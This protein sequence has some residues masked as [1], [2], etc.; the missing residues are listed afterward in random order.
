MHTTTLRSVA[1]SVMMVLPQSLLDRLDLDAGGAVDLTIENGRLIVA[2]RPVPHPSL[3]DLLAEHTSLDR[4]PH[5]ERAWLD[6]GP[7]G[8]EF[9]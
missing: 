8:R 4:R 5:E 3:D 1:G 2:P 9:L 7:A 6:N